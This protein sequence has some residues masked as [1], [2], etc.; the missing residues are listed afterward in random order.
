MIRKFSPHNN[1]NHNTV[2]GFFLALIFSLSSLSAGVDLSWGKSYLLSTALTKY[3]FSDKVA[4][5]SPAIC[6]D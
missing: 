4:L 2:I 5:A 3:I 6:V 1:H